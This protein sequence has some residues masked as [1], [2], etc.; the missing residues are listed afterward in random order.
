VRPAAR[1]V[2]AA[3]AFALIGCGGGSRGSDE[4][5]VRR[6]AKQYAKSVADG[7]TETACELMSTD[8]KSDLAAGGALL[9]AKGGCPG[10][11]RAALG[12][13]DKADRAKLRDYRVTSVKITG[14]KAVAKD[15]TDLDAGSNDPTYLVRKNGEWL[16]DKDPTQN[17]SSGQSTTETA[18]ST[19]TTE[20]APAQKTVGVGERLRQS[21]YMVTVTAVRT[22][23][24]LPGDEY[25]DPVKSEAG[26]LVIL[27]LRV[28]NNAKK[29]A[30]FDNSN[31][32]LV[33]AD[34][35]VYSSA[36]GAAENQIQAL[37]GD[38]DEREIQPKTTESGE[39][40]FDVAK[41]AKVAR[42]QFSDTL[43]FLDEHFT[44]AIELGS[45][46]N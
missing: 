1:A 36:T 30:T 24:E 45:A 28:R 41:S 10:I 21:D 26:R 35:T 25:T 46:A 42:A 13:L 31:V 43:N 38:L 6:V 39:L 15:N 5:Q 7:R 8:A 27:T 23:S 12:F 19:D 17:A 14:D 29:V 16:I 22:A 20:T 34:G 40:A 44:G 18:P 37:P 2:P 4:D 33:D 9:G 11:L 3:L 32:E